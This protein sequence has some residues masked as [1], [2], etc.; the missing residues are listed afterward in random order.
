MVVLP[1]HG[2]TIKVGILIDAIEKSAITIEE[3]ETLL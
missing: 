2:G 1:F 3:F